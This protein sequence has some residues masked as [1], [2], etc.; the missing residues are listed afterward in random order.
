MT[1]A[2]TQGLTDDEW[3]KAAAEIFTQSLSMSKA[4]R[5]ALPTEKQRQI[6]AAIIEECVQENAPNPEIDFYWQ[7]PETLLR[8]TRDGKDIMVDIQNSTKA[9]W[10]AYA[11]RIKGTAKAGPRM[12]RFI[13]AMLAEYDLHPECKTWADLRIINLATRNCF[14]D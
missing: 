7:D 11:E 14:Q 3:A 10:E 5:R 2:E 13:S 12:T 8:F 4:E 6:A 9:H 1:Y